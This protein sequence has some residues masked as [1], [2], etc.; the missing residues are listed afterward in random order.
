LPSCINSNPVSEG[1]LSSFR[2][3][4]PFIRNEVSISNEQ[5]GMRAALSKK[6][7]SRLTE[8]HSKATLSPS[9]NTRTLSGNSKAASRV[10]KRP[11][12]GGGSPG[13]DRHPAVT[14]YALADWWVRYLLPEAFCSIRFVAAAPCS[15][16]AWIE[17]LQE[18]LA[19][20]SRR[21][22][23]RLAGNGLRGVDE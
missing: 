15:R 22:T 1:V 18:S 8:V 16:S 17:G 12:K 23:S 9:S 10:W 5:I 21:N 7:H 2:C 20:T 3:D 14:P 19:S 11:S 6:R 13:A 4:S